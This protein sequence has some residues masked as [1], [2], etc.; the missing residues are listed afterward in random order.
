[1]CDHKK[2]VPMECPEGL[3]FSADLQRCDYPEIAQ[4]DLESEVPEDADPRCVNGVGIEQIILPIPGNCTHFE[5]C[6]FYHAVVVPCAA[7]TEFN[8]KTKECDHPEDAECVEGES[9]V[10]E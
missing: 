7:G 4:C 6:D 2:P 8:H 10:E 9:G 5:M 1:M 3:H